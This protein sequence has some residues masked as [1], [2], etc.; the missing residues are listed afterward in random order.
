MSETLTSTQTPAIPRRRHTLR[1]EVVGQAEL[2]AGQTHHLFL[3]LYENSFPEPRL[4]IDVQPGSARVQ[5]LPIRTQ[6]NGD[7]ILSYAFKN[8]WDRACNI[9]VRMEPTA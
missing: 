8:V 4:Y 9:V 6:Q 2:G 7:Y 1:T 5:I 3:G